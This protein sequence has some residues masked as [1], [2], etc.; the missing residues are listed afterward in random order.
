M[1]THSSF[2]QNWTIVNRVFSWSS[3][4]VHV[5]W[6]DWV[7]NCC[8]GNPLYSQKSF[9]KLWQV[10]QNCY[11]MHTFCFH[12]ILCCVLIADFNVA[13]LSARRTQLVC[14]DSGSCISC[15]LFFLNCNKGKSPSHTVLLSQHGSLHA[16]VWHSNSLVTSSLFDFVFDCSQRCHSNLLW[17]SEGKGRSFSGRYKCWWWLQAWKYPHPSSSCHWRQYNQ[18]KEQIN[19]KSD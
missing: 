1:S 9:S 5:L 19:V 2:G 12:Y 17:F 18:L 15:R 16:A 3:T 11:S 7:L 4:C 8:E 13:A 14:W 6:N 10:C